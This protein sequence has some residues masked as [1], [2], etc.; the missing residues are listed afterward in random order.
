MGGWKEIVFLQLLLAFVIG[1]LLAEYVPFQWT[2]IGLGPALALVGVRA[3]PRRS[4]GAKIRVSRWSG[5][6]T[7][8]TLVAAGMVASK[9]TDD[10]NHPMHYGAHTGATHYVAVVDEPPS[11][12]TKVI[13]IK[14]SLSKA[15]E[16]NR[17][18]NTFGDTYLYMRKSDRSRALSY[19]DVLLI[20]NTLQEA[21]PDPNPHAIDYRFILHNKQIYRTGFLNDTQ[22]T[23]LPYTERNDVFA[24]AFRLRSGILRII[25]AYI[26]SKEAAV[27]ASLLMGYRDAM[28]FQLENAYAAAGVVHILA[29]SGMHV[30]LI[31]MLFNSILQFRLFRFIPDVLKKALMLAF[32]WFFAMLTG[33]SGSVVRACAMLTVYIVGMNNN[34]YT[35]P[36]NL[37][38]ASTFA[39]LVWSPRLLFDVGFE[40][41][42][43]AVLGIMIFQRPIYDA[44]GTHNPALDWVLKMVSI[45]ASAQLSTLPLILYY[46]HQ[47][48][49]HFLWAKFKRF[50]SSM[51][52]FSSACIHCNL[53]YS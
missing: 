44:I 34:R 14:A 31:F 45:S 47:F 5:V 35:S 6:L 32:I 28:D 22:W 18:V 24:F 4:I 29:V 23:L 9:L 37:L 33:F 50:L 21:E 1:I 13:R 41:S 46:F 26:P 17:A 15:V 42:F 2:W 40:L 53:S 30:G 43:F 7:H 12:K 19:G 39:L 10:C 16:N 8:A 48:P 36:L 20:G 11:E 38:F 27:A 25:D 51:R 52:L 49:V 3:W